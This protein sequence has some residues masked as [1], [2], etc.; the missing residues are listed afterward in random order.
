MLLSRA[1]IARL[2]RIFEVLKE[3]LQPKRGG[4][5]LRH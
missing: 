2:F 1:R 5:G 3:G 4:E